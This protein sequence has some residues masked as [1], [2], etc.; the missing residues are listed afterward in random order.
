[1]EQLQLN[2]LNF[3]YKRETIQILATE[4]TKRFGFAPKTIGLELKNNI[5][6]I[7]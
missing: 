7:Q 1:L 5:I 6:K 3:V 4:K 2:N